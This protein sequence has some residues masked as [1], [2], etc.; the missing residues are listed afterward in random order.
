MLSNEPWLK[1]WRDNSLERYGNPEMALATVDKIPFL[2]EVFFS[3]IRNDFLSRIETDDAKRIYRI[4]RVLCEANGQD[5][6]RISMGFP[7]CPPIR[8]AK[9]TV[10][11]SLPIRPNWALYW[12]DAVKAIDA[13]EHDAS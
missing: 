3:E 13:V 1:F 11:I 7:D 12:Q 4:A 5:P 6:D 9:N 2:L 8:D 10:G